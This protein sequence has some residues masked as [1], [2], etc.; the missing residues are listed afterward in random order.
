[1]EE[2]WQNLNQILEYTEKEHSK[3]HNLKKDKQTETWA[4]GQANKLNDALN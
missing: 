4:K 1:M 2:I 3:L